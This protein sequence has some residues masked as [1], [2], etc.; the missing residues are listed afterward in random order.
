MAS[1]LYD[2]TVPAFTRGLR[3]LSGI[4]EKG[5]AFAA[6]KGIDPLTLAQARLIEDMAP[7]TGQIQRA[8]DTAK[9]TIVSIAEC[10]NVAF[11][12]DEQ[13]FDDMQARIAKTIAFLDAVP[14]DTVDG[15]EDKEVVLGT[16][17]GDFRF[18]GRSY[19]LTFALPNFYFHVTTAYALLRQAG[20]QI[21]KLDYLRME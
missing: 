8:S 10:E 7:L 15:C 14:R 2:L 17:R 1:E 13:S 5:A 21:G 20:V 12:D 16:P 3:N 18:T 11:A 19:V 4:L 6:E 9:F